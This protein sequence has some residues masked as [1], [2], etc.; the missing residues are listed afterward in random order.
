MTLFSILY[1]LQRAEWNVSTIQ[2]RLLPPG[3]GVSP[4]PAHS[5]AAAVSLSAYQSDCGVHSTAAAP[6]SH[7]PPYIFCGVTHVV[8]VA[9][10]YPLSAYMNC[11]SFCGSM[12]S[13]LPTILQSCSFQSLNSLCSTLDDKWTPVSPTKEG[14][15]LH[16]LY[17]TPCT[18]PY[19]T[20]QVRELEYL[21][22]RLYGHYIDNREC[23][24]CVESVRGEG[25]YLLPL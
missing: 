20:F 12:N 24:S 23:A 17:S 4:V 10:N 25:K 18:R 2:V 22:T 6:K 8:I 1:H 14:Q 21:K 16:M 3:S 9:C 7:D 11:D 5:L 15:S 13:E 19:L